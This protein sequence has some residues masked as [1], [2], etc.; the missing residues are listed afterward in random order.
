MPFVVTIIDPE[1]GSAVH[2]RTFTDFE[3][4]DANALECEAKAPRLFTDIK[5]VD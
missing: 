5:E 4:A 3:Q 1:D 2:T